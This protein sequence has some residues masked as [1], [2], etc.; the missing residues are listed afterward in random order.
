VADGAGTYSVTGIGGGIFAGL[1]FSFDDGTLFY[2]AEWADVISPQ[3]GA[4]AALNY[5][6]GAGNAGIQVAG[7]EGRGSV[8]M[9]GFP[10][11]TITTAANRAAVID[12]V[13]EFFDL[14]AI[15]PANADFNNDG[16]VDAADYIVWRKHNNT[17]VPHGTLGDA[18]HNGQVNSDDY[19]TWRTQ[20]GTSPGNA[21][22]AT[23]TDDALSASESSQPSTVIE[24]QSL[25]PVDSPR[26]AAGRP[27]FAPA[28]RPMGH[29][30]GRDWSAL[31]SALAEDSLR[32]TD[33]YQHGALPDDPA[34]QPGSDASSEEGS[35]LTTASSL[36]TQP[37]EVGP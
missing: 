20:F 29:S 11:E 10:F 31:L 3:A 25:A 27:A 21:A 5:S 1:N 15:L 36:L 8:V 30:P 24:F 14:A 35:W 34:K 16:V 7:A 4:Q 9:F 33:K 17:S 26:G 2:N 37:L 18:D 12:R 6:N 28:K 22:A 13:L 32:S 23:A 19:Q